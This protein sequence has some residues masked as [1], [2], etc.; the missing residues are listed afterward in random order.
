VILSS[1][2]SFV[3]VGVVAVAVAAR[4]AVAVA[5]PP[6]AERAAGAALRRV[7]AVVV[8]LAGVP[9]S[10]ALRRPCVRLAGSL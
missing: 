7:L 10:V 8:V 1:S 2:T 3:R 6:V 4:G 5:A 9:A